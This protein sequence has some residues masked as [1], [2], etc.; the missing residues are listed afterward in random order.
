MCYFSFV[1][2]FFLYLIYENTATF[3]EKIQ[4]FSSVAQLQMKT[5]CNE[6]SASAEY[7]QVQN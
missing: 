3:G 7:I 1:I 6:A 4:I 2:T 5:N